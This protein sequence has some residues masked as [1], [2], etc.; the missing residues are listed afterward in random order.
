[1]QRAVDAG[2]G[3][4]ARSLTVA[5]KLGGDGALM[6]RGDEAL[7][8]PAAEVEV[9]D[10]TGAGDAFDAGFIFGLLDGRSSAETLALAVACGSLCTRAL[11]GVDG[12]AT[13]E[14]A[15]ALL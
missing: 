3:A 13:L 10:P 15:E 4:D 11:G 14:E 2:R 7:R 6:V 1:M 5:I 12:Q 9:V 8:L